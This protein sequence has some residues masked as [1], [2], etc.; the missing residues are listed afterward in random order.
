MSLFDR[1]SNSS[2]IVTVTHENENRLTRVIN[3]ETKN[4]ISFENFDRNSSSS[5]S[6][7]LTT[8]N[9]IIEEEDVKNN[10]EEKK[11]ENKV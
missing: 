8:N 10:K 2:D 9:L 5:I 4:P 7:P 6:N 11:I 1:F 3:Y